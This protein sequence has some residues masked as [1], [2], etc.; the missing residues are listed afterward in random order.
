MCRPSTLARNNENAV[1]STSLYIVKPV[2]ASIVWTV[3]KIAQ[4]IRI[5]IYV[6]NTWDDL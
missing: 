2:L 1:S 3:K 6:Y 4:T 5:H